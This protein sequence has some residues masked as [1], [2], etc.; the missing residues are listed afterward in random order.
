VKVK[1]GK[2]QEY[3]HRVVVA[4][5]AGVT[6]PAILDLEVV[7]A[8]EGE[9]V[10]ARRLINRILANYSRLIDVIT[11]DAL[12]LEA[13][14]LRMLLDA[15]KHFVI[16]MK[17]EQRDLFQDADQLRSLINP[18]QIKDGDCT[19]RLWDISDLTSFTTLG[20]SVRV[21][22]AEE[23]HVTR[24]V[25]GGKRQE[26][27]VQ[28][29]W[30]WVTDLSASLVSATKIQLWG[31]DRWDLENRGFNELATLWHMDHCFVHN[32]TAIGALLLTLAVAFLTTYLFFERNLKPAARFRLTRLALASRL[33][34][35]L[36]HCN[37]ETIWPSLKRS[38]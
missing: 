16:V 1:G 9:V 24:K 32:T 12:Y 28:K 10:A 13:P 27:I 23:Q 6:P 22:W 29:T 26:V 25:I 30:I 34:E 14:F 5:W 21:I 19:T 15:G 35:D 7:G 8:G 17:Q 37:G 38:G 20:Q 4:Q 36:L 2:V 33:L 18:R 3:Y 31:H 11:A